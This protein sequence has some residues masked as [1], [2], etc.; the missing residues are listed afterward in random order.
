MTPP[1]IPEELRT[2]RLR[3][4][5][6]GPVDFDALAAMHADPRAMAPLGG[7]RSDRETRAYLDRAL[8]QWGHDGFGLWTV[9]GVDGRFLGRGGLRRTTVAG[10]DEVELAY[11]LVPEAWGQG[12]AT[13]LARESTRIGFTALASDALVALAAPANAASRRVLAKTG[14]QEEGEVAHGDAPHLL[15][16]LRRDDWRLGTVGRLEAIWIKRAHWGPM[17]PVPAAGLAAGR[18]LAGNA[19]Q[20]RKRQVTI[21]EREVWDRLVGSLDASTAPPARRANLLVSGCGLVASRN[22]ILRVGECRLRIAGETRPCERMDEA[23][24]GLR[25]AMRT[26]WGG[27]A[28]AEVLDDGRIE[29]GAELRW[30][31][32]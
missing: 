26:D 32:S 12:L 11:A 24:P 4:R 10:R 7:V 13:E 20:G 16:R 27:G 1:R 2:G 31:R 9:R 23:L 6:M 8:G 29:V 5:R 25:E 19:D 14:F 18:G 17:D 21:I 28:F 3:L 30:E 15:A 22:W